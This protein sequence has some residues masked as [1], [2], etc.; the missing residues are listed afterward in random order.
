MN[1]ENSCVE[2]Y[3]KESHQGDYQKG[4][5]HSQIM[6]I[7]YHEFHEAV[8]RHRISLIDKPWVQPLIHNCT[9][10]DCN[11]NNNYQKYYSRTSSFK[12]S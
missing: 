9:D 12:D 3:H 5:N 8:K 6:I 7:I 10:P 1:K 11:K 4:K 2:I